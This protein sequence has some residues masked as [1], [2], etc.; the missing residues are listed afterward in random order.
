[1]SEDKDPLDLA[2][3]IVDLC[4]ADQS[5]REKLL[6]DLEAEDPLLRDTVSALL[7]HKDRDPE[8]ALRSMQK[9]RDQARSSR[10]GRGREGRD[11]K[12]EHE[13]QHY[14]AMHGINETLAHFTSRP[15]PLSAGTIFEYVRRGDRKP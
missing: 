2:I 14:Y 9:L 7:A 1:M 8:G 3:E 12:T 13:V 15:E 6:S 5:R 11:I 10:R 4:L